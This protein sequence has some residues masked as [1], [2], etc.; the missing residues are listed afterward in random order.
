MIK[1]EGLYKTFESK[2]ANEVHAINGVDLTIN[3]GDFITVIGSNGAGKSTLLNLISGSAIA[4][5]GKIY[6][7][8]EDVTKL[9]EY[10]RA[11]YVGRV[12]QDPN[13]GTCPLLSILENM[14][15]AS[16]RGKKRTLKL[17]MKK[18]EV[19]GYLS[20]LETLNLG[21]ENRARTKAGLLSGGQRQ[22][23]T[24]LMATLVKPKILLLDEHTAA[25]DPK[26]ASLVLK[27]TEEIIAKDNL[28][29]FMV[30]HN[31]K[32]ALKY[33]N[34]LI[35][36]NQGKIVLDINAEEKKNLT[37]ADLLKKFE[38]A[39]GSEIVNDNVLLNN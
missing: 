36:M 11:K 31:M 12:F 8:E 1:I 4:D 20:K 3:D 24:L 5:G 17:G 16:R 39:T 2:T 25:L 22:A 27:T 7:D 35:M 33:G 30:T 19:N 15:I 28:T 9:P 18:D 10:K 37:V 29:A 32:D 6:I 26:T 14:S 38:E 23:L 13:V 21:L 34:R